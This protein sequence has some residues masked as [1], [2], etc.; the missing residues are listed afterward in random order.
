MRNAYY[1][2]DVVHTVHLIYVVRL[3]GVL[4]CSTSP[5]SAVSRVRSLILPEEK[6]MSAG[7]FS[8]TAAGNRAY[9]TSSLHLCRHF[10]YLLTSPRF[11][12]LNRESESSGSQPVYRKLIPRG[13]HSSKNNFFEIIPANALRLPLCS[14]MA[15]ANL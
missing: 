4:A 5:M 3:Y 10:F 14:I 15:L 2:Q 12:A 8:R 9:S 11:C 6:G 7:S 1:L 13:P